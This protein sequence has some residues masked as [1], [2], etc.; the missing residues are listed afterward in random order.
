MFEGLP[1]EHQGQILHFGTFVIVKSCTVPGI[2]STSGLPKSTVLP[3]Q[4]ATV[5]LQYAIYW[6]E[7]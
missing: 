1:G 5:R 3:Y 2:C 6:S 4:L 7:V